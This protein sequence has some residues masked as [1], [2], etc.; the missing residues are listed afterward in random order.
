[1]KNFLPFYILYNIYEND[2]LFEQT[3]KYEEFSLSRIKA[4]I[5]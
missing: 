2:F 1:M 3:K 4:N 5:K